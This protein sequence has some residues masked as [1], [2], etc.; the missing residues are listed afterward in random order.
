LRKLQLNIFDGTLRDTIGAT[1]RFDPIAEFGNPVLRI[2]TYG[3]Q[4]IA[5]FVR[6]ELGY[7]PCVPLA[8]KL[9]LCVRESAFGDRPRC[10]LAPFGCLFG[11][12]I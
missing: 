3:H 10:L 1:L 7:R 2:C 9:I 8:C 6:S 5:Q 12:A 11:S 4:L